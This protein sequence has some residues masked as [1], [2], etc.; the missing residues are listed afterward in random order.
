[1]TWSAW[2]SRGPGSVYNCFLYFKDTAGQAT[3]AALP[4]PQWAGAYRS[5]DED[6]DGWDSRR[7][8]CHFDDTPLFHPY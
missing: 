5:S 2:G 1:M 4:P 3:L 6:G 8:D 7:R